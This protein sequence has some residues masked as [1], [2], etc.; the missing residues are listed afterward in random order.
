MADIESLGYELVYKAAEGVSAPD[1]LDGTNGK[2]AIRSQLRALEGMQKEALVYDGQSGVQW[3]MVCDEGPYLN[4]TDLAPSPLAFY[5]TGMAFS[6]TSELLKH[7]KAAG[8]EIKNYKMTQNNFYTMEGSAIRGNM[9]GGALPAEIVVE[10]ESDAPTEAVQAI[11]NQA[12]QT[13]PAQR[14][15]NNDMENTFALSHN[16]QSIDPTDV[17][18]S[19]NPI[20]PEPTPNLE[21]AKPLSDDRYERGII[22]KETG[23]KTLFGVDGGAGSSLQADQKR[24]LHLRGIVSLLDNGLMACDVQLFKPLGGI[25]RFLGDESGKV[26]APSSLSFLSAGVAFCFMTQ[27]GRYA[28]IVK[29]DLKGYSVVQD[30]TFAIGEEGSDAYPVDTHTYLEMGD[31]AEAA[32]KNLF[33][34]ERTC[35]LHAAMRGSTKTVINLKHN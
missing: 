20:Q 21:S 32:Q 31:S 24:T 4:G 23:A 13:S 28:H 5:T 19:S 14:Y 8:I 6:F 27:I 29:Q 3:R 30:T 34:S 22:V 35:F 17:T 26:R 33:M 9:I 15:M 18:P 25:F 16:G 2:I 12:E 1:N 10:I 7:A 11:V